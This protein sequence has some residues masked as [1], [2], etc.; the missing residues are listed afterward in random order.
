MD[1]STN[2]LVPELRFP[3]FVNDGEWEEKVLS[4]I[5]DA[6]FDGT[7]QTP[8]YTEKGVPFLALRILLVEIKINIFPEKITNLRQIKTNH[9]RAIFYSQELAKL[10]FQRLL[11]G[12]TILVFM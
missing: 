8:T 7:H 9:T 2:K 4:E 12:I 3:E 1:N 10:D 6:V 5:T 11:I